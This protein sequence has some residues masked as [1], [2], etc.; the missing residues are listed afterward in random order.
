MLKGLDLTV[1]CP[2]VAGLVLWCLV[3]AACVRIRWPA[4]WYGP[5]NLSQ[6]LEQAG[7]HDV[8]FLRG[9]LAAGIQVSLVSLQALSAWKGCLLGWANVTFLAA[10]SAV[11]LGLLLAGAG[12]VG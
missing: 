1:T 3:I 5:T 9:K 11:L 2:L 8:T 6:L 7:A 12:P 4:R 10:L